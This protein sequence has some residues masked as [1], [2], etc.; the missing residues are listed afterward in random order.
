MAKIKKISDLRPADYNPREITESAL[1]GLGKSIEEFGDLSGIVFNKRTGNLVAGHQRVRTLKEQYGDLEIKNGKIKLP[2]GEVFTVRVVDWE[3][4]KEKL[5]NVSANNPAIQGDW[6]NGLDEMLDGLQEIDFALFQ[7]LKLD[8]IEVP[9]V[10]EKP[11][12]EEGIPEMELKAFEHYDFIVLVFSDEL[13]W[14]NAVQ[15]FGL[16]K[17]NGS[18]NPK[19]KKIG[20]GRVVR[21]E[22]VLQMIG[23]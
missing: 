5:A 21:G 16:K 6:T 15:K 12:K 11:E 8:E 17:V 10:G 23:N 1:N 4:D 9:T 3:E 13:S 18:W 19:T 2:G 20:L 22:K 14:I 7:E